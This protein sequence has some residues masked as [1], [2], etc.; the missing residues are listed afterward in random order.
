MKIGMH[1]TIARGLVCGIL[2]L[3]A[4]SFMALPGTAAPRAAPADFAAIDRYVEQELQATRLPGLALGIVQG[5]QIVHLKGFGVAD[6]SGRPVTPQTP[7][8]IGSTTKSMTAL[9]IMQ[10]VEAGKV[11]LDAPVQRY[12]PWFHIA[13]AEASARITV[14]QLLNHTSGLPTT[15][16]GEFVTSPDMSDGALE[17]RVRALG[18]AELSAPVGTIWQFC[19]ANYVVLGLIVQTVAGQS[20]ETYL[21]EHLFTPLAMHQ[22]F[23][24][25]VAAQQHGLAIGY[26]YWFGVPVS[27]D[28]PYYRGELPAG[29]VISSAEDMAQYL[30][31]H[32]NAG[33]YRGAQILSPAGIAELHRPAVPLMG[34]SDI[35]YGMGWYIMPTNGVPTVRHVGETANFHANIVLV[36]EG[37][38]GVVL[39][40]N[41]NSAFLGKSRIEGI[42]VGVTSLLVGRALPDAASFYDTIIFYIIILGIAALQV[43]GIIRS[44]GKLRRWRTQPARRPHGWLALM[45]HVVMPVVLNLIPAL[46]FLVG[47]PQ[48]FGPLSGLIYVAPDLGYV[49]VVSGVVAL[50]WSV[51]RTGLAL[52]VL[53]TRGALD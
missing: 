32:L 31:A 38:W 45:W 10:L 7:F 13:D 30:I 42:A 6:P 24:S 53:R 39:L 22:T 47:A 33:H 9:A 43:V 26:R 35:F 16:G 11:E 23:T 34:A 18:T 20:Y 51:L 21:Q 12:L 2:A 5:D 52:L 36:P 29:F 37:R 27:A 25:P 40:M 46:L 28:M 41:G 44:L 8:I 3:L 1:L 17:Q 19:N 15:T 49:M 50:S 48:L 14:R 4:L